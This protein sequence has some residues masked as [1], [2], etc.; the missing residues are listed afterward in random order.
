MSRPARF[1]L[2]RPGHAVST[3]PYHIG[4]VAKVKGE[5]AEGGRSLCDRT[6]PAGTVENTDCGNTATGGAVGDLGA[7]TLGPQR[8]TPLNFLSATIRAWVPL[9]AW[10]CAATALYSWLTSAKPGRA[11]F[12]R[13]ASSNA[14]CMSLMKCST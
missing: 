11:I 12:I 7:A 4:P 5:L 8:Y 14:I 10:P 9:R 6:V 1:A 3:A 13:A 2:P